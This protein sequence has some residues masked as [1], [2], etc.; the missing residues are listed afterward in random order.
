MDGNF[1]IPAAVAE[2]LMQSHAGTIDFLP[3][4]PTRWATSGSFTG[5]KAR[6]GFTVDCT[7][8][9]GKV[10]DYKVRSKVPGKVKVRVNGETR[11]IMCEMIK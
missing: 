8:K 5:L 3:A 9:N 7:W 4:L 6:G 10:I 1:G 11:E 2:M